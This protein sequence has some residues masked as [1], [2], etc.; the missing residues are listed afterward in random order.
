MQIVIDTNVLFAV[1]YSNKGA[2][3]KLISMIG[4]KKFEFHLSVPL[5]IEYEDV[6]LR[7][8]SK[9]GLTESDIHNFLN[10]IC[11]AGIHHVVYYLWR[12]SL[13]DPRDEM[14]LEVA[15]KAGCDAIVTYNKSDFGAAS[16]FGLDVLSAYEFLDK[17]D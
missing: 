13:K 12:P 14:L 7:N 1:L 17:L 4:L 16:R 15:V 3:F 10:F 9:F 5:V 2:S 6:L 8:A 11:E